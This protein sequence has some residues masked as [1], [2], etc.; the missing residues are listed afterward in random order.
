[1]NGQNIKYISLFEAAKLTS[2]SQEYISLLCRQKKM[3]G[4]KI[5]RNWVTTKEW[6]R[7]YIDRTKGKGQNIIPVKIKS[8]KNKELSSEASELSSLSSLAKNTP[9]GDSIPPFM[10]K[11]ILTAIIC[12]LFV[13]GFIFLQLG[14]QKGAIKANPS[15]AVK[16]A[17]ANIAEGI[18]SVS[19]YLDAIKNKSAEF[20][21]DKIIAL[22]DSLNIIGNMA[23]KKSANEMAE[24]SESRNDSNNSV[25]TSADSITDEND[26]SKS[27][28]TKKSP[29]GGDD[30]ESLNSSRNLGLAPVDNSIAHK[31][32]LSTLFQILQEKMSNINNFFGGGSAGNRTP[33]TQVLTLSSDHPEPTANLLYQ[34]N[35]EKSKLARGIIFLSGSL[36]LVKNKTAKFFGNKITGAG[37]ALNNIKSQIVFLENLNNKKPSP[38]VAGVEDLNEGSNAISGEKNN[39]TNE[40]KKGMVVV[41]LEGDKNSQENIDIINRISSSFSDDVD[42]RPNEDGVSGIINPKNNPEENYLYLMVPV[43]E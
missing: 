14:F 29:N 1:M 11:L 36:D 2:Y 18:I 7:D 28:A 13:S 3:K 16:G 40:E 37:N 43:N 32:N 33:E 4:T 15:Q 20:A 25:L 19:D 35:S 5:G 9:A 8:A 24:V 10:G 23:N 17:S 27:T 22:D 38:R 39:L 26:L 41:P 21:S 12:S 6:V 42:V 30:L 31:N 34:I